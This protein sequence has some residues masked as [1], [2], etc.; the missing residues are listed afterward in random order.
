MAK[1]IGSNPQHASNL[2]ERWTAMILPLLIAGAAAQV[3]VRLNTPL[4]LDQPLI[5]LL[6]FFLLPALLVLLLAKIRRELGLGLAIVWPLLWQFLS[7]TSDDSLA[8]WL[9]P[10]AAGVLIV[11]VWRHAGRWSWPV[12]VLV[13]LVAFFGP[14]PGRPDSGPRLLVFGLDG[15]TWQIVDKLASEGRLPN[16]QNAMESGYGARLRSL[17]STLSPQ[18]WTT[19]ATGY[20]PEVHGAW[21]FVG[22]RDQIKV[23]RVWDQLLSEGRS[24]GLCGWYFTWPPLPGL[25]QDDFVIPSQLAPGGDTHPDEFSFFWQ[26]WTSAQA[27]SNGPLAYLRMG[28]DSFRNGVRVSTLLRSTREVLV[29][30]FR[31]RSDMESDWR[32]RAISLDLQGDISVELLRTRQPEF[33]AFLFTQV[34]RVCHKYWKFME[35]DLFPEVTEAEQQRYG[36]VIPDAYAAADLVLGRMLELIP[37]NADVLI[38]SDHGFQADVGLGGKWCGIKTEAF[39]DALGLGETAFATYVLDHVLLRPLSE[40]SA[41]ADSLLT[42]LEPV[43]ASAHVVGESGPLLTVE[44]DQNTFLLTLAPRNTIP[45]NGVISMGGQEFPFDD[46]ISAGTGAT[47]S[48]NH[49]PDGVFLLSGPSAMRSVRSDSLNV[50][51]VAPTIS[52]LLDLP[53]CP[54]WTGRAAISRTGDQADIIMA[55]FPLPP[56]AGLDGETVD[57]ALIKKLKSIGYVR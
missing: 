51:D 32:K 11:L 36:N 15:A 44:R 1:I 22:N 21:D 35:P 13:V 52:A 37:E 19:I 27:G 24:C 6:L 10:A 3:A 40:N 8:V 17:P 28:L 9:V 47:W 46:L 34:D 31:P 16:F 26:I 12:A 30:R 41:Y 18:V 7:R 4:T 25:G 38:V 50:L 48:G 2:N 53:I 29:N 55:E 20:P 33:A 42:A 57:E 56:K 54:G 43:V 5:S 23:G 49:H 14:G 45:E 39:L